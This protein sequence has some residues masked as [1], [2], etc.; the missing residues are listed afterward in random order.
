LKQ[1]KKDGH[2]W[3]I[4][5]ETPPQEINQFKKMLD[6]NLQK[7]NSDYKAKRYKN[8]ALKELDL[9]VLPKGLFHKWLKQKGKFGG[10]NKVPRLC[11]DRRYI[12]QLLA[13]IEGE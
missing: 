6:L 10:Q 1:E 5:F 4:E 11:N 8:L 12:E 13:L 2:Q 9:T 3:L 7:V